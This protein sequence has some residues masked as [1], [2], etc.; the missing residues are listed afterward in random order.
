MLQRSGLSL[1]FHC[2]FVRSFVSAIIS[3]FER[4]RL[5]NKYFRSASVHT[6]SVLGSSVFVCPL[7][8]I[9]SP[10]TRVSV[11]RVI[12]IVINSLTVNGHVAFLFCRLKYYRLGRPCPRGEPNWPQRLA[13]R[14]CRTRSVNNAAKRNV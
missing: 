7:L 9:R 8:R 11:T 5:S 10:K 2:S 4:I 12:F 13:I 14:R 6:G 1:K 3:S